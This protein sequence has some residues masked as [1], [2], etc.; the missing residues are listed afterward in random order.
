MGA[1]GL[2]AALWLVILETRQAEVRCLTRRPD[3]EAAKT[4]QAA[5]RG[6]SKS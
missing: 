5:G 3:S 6:S 1:T 2:K 4:L